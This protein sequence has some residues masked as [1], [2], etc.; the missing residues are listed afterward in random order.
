MPGGW[1]GSVAS[2]IAATRGTG[3]GAAASGTGAGAARMTGDCFFFWRLGRGAMVSGCVVG[4]AGD[5]LFH[6]N[7]TTAI[8]FHKAFW[9]ND[10]I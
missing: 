1:V 2:T 4:C 9:S 7:L 6:V 5:V 8:R 3:A 10:G